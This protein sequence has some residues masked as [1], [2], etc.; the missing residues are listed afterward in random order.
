MKARHAHELVLQKHAMA[1]AWGKEV[2]EAKEERER[3]RA[4]HVALS[5]AMERR[6]HQHQRE[7]RTAQQQLSDVQALS[8]S[9]QSTIDSLRAQLL[10]LQARDKAREDAPAPIPP[11]DVDSLDGLLLTVNAL[12][13][14]LANVRAHRSA[15]TQRPLSDSQ[16]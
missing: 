15:R 16:A 13:A 2:R 4:Q 8:L 1:A 5:R 11:A 12:K 3:E 14:Q 10:D 9:Q 6:F 7:L